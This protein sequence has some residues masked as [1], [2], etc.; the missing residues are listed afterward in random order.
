MQG[1]DETDDVDPF[2][3]CLTP[4]FSYGVFI[5]VVTKEEGLG[6][7]SGIVIGGYRGHRG[8]HGENRCESRSPADGPS[9][10]TIRK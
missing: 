7:G 3:E 8:P 2:D 1:R 5:C 9:G 4:G 6:G 10:P